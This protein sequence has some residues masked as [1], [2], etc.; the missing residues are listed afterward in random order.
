M[1]RLS[2]SLTIWWYKRLG[3][4]L[5]GGLLLIGTVMLSIFVLRGTI[6][7]VW[8]FTPVSFAILAAAYIRQFIL[9]LAD[10]VF[11]AGDALL[12]RRGRGTTRVALR[13]ITSVDYL[14]VFDPPR[15]SLRF[16]TVNGEQ[17]VFFMPYLFPG[18]CSFRPHPLVEH[19]RGRI[20]A[21]APRRH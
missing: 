2:S 5:L 19:L 21:D 20:G 17:I 16:T 1:Q 12:V 18:M 8:L 15:I 4:L 14:L 11:D 10:E 7:S 13:E 9:P 3:P 6:A